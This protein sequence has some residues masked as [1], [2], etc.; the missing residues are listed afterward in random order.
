MKRKRIFVLFLFLVIAVS[1]TAGIFSY[2]SFIHRS[3]FVLQE[4]YSR[5][6]ENKLINLLEPAVGIGNIRV[7]VQTNI[8]HQNTTQKQY[9]P[10][11]LAETQ[12]YEE[13]PVLTKQSVSVLI[14][15]KSQKRLSTYYNLIKAAVGFDL[16]RGDQ[17]SVVILPFVTIPLWTLGLTPLT[18]VR[19]GAV[20]ILM[21]LLGSLWLFKE[22]HKNSQKKSQYFYANSSKLNELLK[23]SDEEI[24]KL[25]HYVSKKDLVKALQGCSWAIQNVF[26]RNIPP[27]LWQELMYQEKTWS[28][29]ETQ[30]AQK[31]IIR[32]AE[33]LKESE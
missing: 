31:K 24:Q 22:W 28:V 30:K 12:T 20:L 17:L 3:P 10:F 4:K 33:L 1:I 21:I 32:L 8:T 13:G 25:L 19:I 23:W 15:G 2:P 5:Y 26:K 6:L 9:N 29:E 7:N 16:N 14:N 18:L 11:T 27:T